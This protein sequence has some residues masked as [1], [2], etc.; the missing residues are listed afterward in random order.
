MLLLHKNHKF[1]FIFLYYKQIYDFSYSNTKKAPCS[2]KI[3]GA[4]NIRLPL[5]PS[6]P[7]GVGRRV[8]ARLLIQGT[9]YYYKKHVIVNAQARAAAK[10]SSAPGCLMCML[11]VQARAGAQYPARSSQHCMLYV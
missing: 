3:R 2:R 10:A 9:S 4:A 5:L 1:S 6:G 11:Y 8:L 7:G